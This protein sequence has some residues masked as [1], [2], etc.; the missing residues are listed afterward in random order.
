[1]LP[2]RPGTSDSAARP[3][4]SERPSSVSHAVP[5]RGASA[6]TS[7]DDQHQP[8]AQRQV[9]D[10]SGSGDEAS[11][12]P[13]ADDDGGGVTFGDDDDS[14]DR[15]GINA[16]AIQAAAAKRRQRPGEVLEIKSEDDEFERVMTHLGLMAYRT[17]LAER[18]ADSLDTLREMS[19]DQLRLC[20]LPVPIR[21]KVL[22]WQNEEVY[23]P[24]W[25]SGTF[26]CSDEYKS[27]LCVALCPCYVFNVIY[28]E[29]GVQP[30]PCPLFGCLV[31]L[32]CAFPFFSCIGCFSRQQLSVKY[33][34]AP[35]Y[36]PPSRWVACEDCCCHMF[37]HCCS[38]CQ[39]LREV[40][41]RNT[42]SASGRL[43][44]DLVQAATDPS[45]MSVPKPPAT[46]AKTLEGLAGDDGVGGGG[47]LVPPDRGL[48][49]PDMDR[50]LGQQPGLV[51]V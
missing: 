4:T 32:I 37:C 21:N 47:A 38:M 13:A 25:S 29:A 5:D 50:S 33:G 15:G 31:Y 35:K 1:M 12:R 26:G 6:A 51:H 14:D 20:G 48:R 23:V 11:Q 39:E 27:C 24:R 9:V 43:A 42:A 49:S 44:S 7:G 28:V 8:P 2:G 18:G 17:S 45:Q 19:W 46:P 40:G 34:I 22:A 36:P 16:G 30:N 41:H 3:Q 10:V